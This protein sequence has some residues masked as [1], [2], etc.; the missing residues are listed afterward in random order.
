MLGDAGANPLGAAAGVGLAVAL[1]Q[2]G[3]IAAIALLLVLNAA[4]EVV[5]FSRVIERVPWLRFV[6]RIGRE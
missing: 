6:D 1:S 5:S 3:R 2:G 4:S